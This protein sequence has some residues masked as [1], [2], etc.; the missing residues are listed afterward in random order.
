MT[1][2]LS[3]VTHL[4]DAPAYWFLNAPHV[5]LAHNQSGKDVYSL[6]H[7]TAPVGLETPYHVHEEEDEAFY[8]LDGNLRIV[9]DGRAVIATPGSYVFLPPQSASRLSV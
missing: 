6:I 9:I 1:P 4:D 7:L 3:E 5:L 2:Q 8:V